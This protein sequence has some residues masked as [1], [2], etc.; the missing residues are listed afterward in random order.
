MEDGQ[1]GMDTIVHIDQATRTFFSQNQRTQ[2]TSAKK[3][4][5]GMGEGRP[6]LIPCTIL[7]TVNPTEIPLSHQVGDRVHPLLVNI[8]NRVSIGCSFPSGRDE[9]VDF[10]RTFDL[11]RRNN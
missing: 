7:I 10:E 6:L 11:V 3:C 8:D 5:D 1:V 9:V 2:A 4:K